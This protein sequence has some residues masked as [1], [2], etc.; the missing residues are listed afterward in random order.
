MKRL[1]SVI[2]IASVLLCLLPA[3]A[4]AERTGNLPR[5]IETKYPSANTVVADT[6]LTEA[7]YYADNTGV[8]DCSAVL[9]RAIDELF[10]AGGGTIFMPVG[11]YRLCSPINVRPF[12]CIVG[13]R[14]DPDLGNEYGTLIVADTAPSGS[15]NPALFTVGGSSGVSGLTVWYE[16]QSI[17]H[18]IPYPYTFYVDGAGSNYMLQT[19]SDITL[20]NSYRGI[21]ACTEWKNGK[22]E[23]HEMLTIENV[24]GTCL[25]EGLC[26]FNS[27][28]VDTVKGLH[29]GGRYWSEAGEKFNAP[30]IEKLNKYTENNLTAFTLGDLEW[31]EMC[32]MSAE[33]CSYGI[34]LAKGPRAAFSGT[35]FNLSLTCCKTGIFAEEGSV[36]EREKQWGY[37]VCNSEI[38]AYNDAVNDYTKGVVMLTNVKVTG[39][40]KGKN[41]HR[42]SASTDRN[43]LDYNRQYVKCSGPLFTVTADK[44]GRNDVSSV[45]QQVLD[46][47]GITGGTVYLPAG[48]YRLDKSVSIPSG[49]ELRGSGYTA[50]RDQSGCS[51]GTLLL[52]YGAYK[53]NGGNTAPLISLEGDNCGLYNVRVSFV[54]NKPAD[55]SGS[56]IETAP[57][58]YAA[59][60]NIHVINCFGILGSE[61]LRAENCENLYVKHLTGCGYHSFIHTEN[62]TNL[63]IESCLQNGNTIPRNGYSSF[64]IEETDNWLNEGNL[65]DYVFIPI[66]RVYTDFLIINSSDGTVFNTFIYGGRRFLSARNSTLF[67]CGVGCDGQSKDFYTYSLEGG[68]TTVIGTLKSTYDGKN[69]K[70]QYECDKN[71]TLRLY[72]RI[73]VDLKYNERTILKNVPLSDLGLSDFA[74]YVFQPVIRLGEWL[75]VAKKA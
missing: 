36:M 55:S 49:V 43:K 70:K 16:N 61:I 60:S 22:Y 58:F 31:P 1:L 66:T 68:S 65:F 32:N 71:A 20:L 3:E 63:L 53:E 15:F 40:I 72:D 51:K 33:H 50:T 34:Y 38:S 19:V 13:D 46:T 25:K 5:I 52:A 30:D 45:L 9:Q 75:G 74:T 59:G 62:C 47:A 48:L 10:N 28:D 37:S 21:G 44:T 29:F 56:F 39:R 12:V 57:A 67:I 27:A 23:C 18:V 26:S 35:F 42:E 73:S 64:G 8:N 24:K 11:S 6:V 17:D 7:P 69:G 2:L 41:I 54:K 4:C 14:Q